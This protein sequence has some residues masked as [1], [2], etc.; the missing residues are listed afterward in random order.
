MKAQLNLKREWVGKEAR[1][2]TSITPLAPKGRFGGVSG[3]SCCCSTSQQTKPDI[4]RKFLN[5]SSIV[6]FCLVLASFVFVS[7][8]FIGF[9]G[10][11]RGLVWDACLLLSCFV[12]LTGTALPALYPQTFQNSL[13]PSTFSPSSIKHGTLN[14]LEISIYE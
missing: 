1:P 5:L 10:V 2:Q 13:L 9:F 3:N 12:C 14:L 8:H 7:P 4:W 6:L 11:H